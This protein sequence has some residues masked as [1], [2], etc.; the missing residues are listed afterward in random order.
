VTTVALA[1]AA[2]EGIQDNNDCGGGGGGGGGGDDD[3]ERAVDHSRRP[4]HLDK[5][6]PSLVELMA[7]E[8]IDD[9]REAL[10]QPRSES[11]ARGAEDTRSSS[12]TRRQFMM[13][14][15]SSSSS[16]SSSSVAVATA[17]SSASSETTTSTTVGAAAATS[18]DASGADAGRGA[19]TSN[20]EE[21]ESE[22][23]PTS[24]IASAKLSAAQPSSTSLSSSSSS[25][26]S[27]LS[28]STPP[29]SAELQA[30]R[31]SRGSNKYERMLAIGISSSGVR[32]KMEQDGVGEAEISATLPPFAKPS[33]PSYST[34]RK[35]PVLTEGVPGRA[36]TKAMSENLMV[37]FLGAE[38]SAALIELS[39]TTPTP[40]TA[41]H[42]SAGTSDAGT[43]TAAS[44]AVPNQD[45]DG[46]R[47]G[48]GSGRSR[49]KGD[50]W[51]FSPVPFAPF[52]FFVDLAGPSSSRAV[53]GSGGASRT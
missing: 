3:D 18:G 8:A 13:A 31:S 41:R 7:L 12:I 34:F 11:L 26:S 47:K 50:K 27:S 53:D 44:P 25:S 37:D 46:G 28:S 1:P 39:S 16:S 42:A 2:A 23:K 49:S 40:A 6:R 21:D 29:D 52:S 17:S 48:G 51:L 24:S 43:T 35:S 22:P 33:S 36:P 45:G 10:S 30:L 32:R 5:R 4:R 38:G 19:S 9:V 14:L 20:D 15:S